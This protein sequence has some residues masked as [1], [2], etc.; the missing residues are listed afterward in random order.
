MILLQRIKTALESSAQLLTLLSARPADTKIYAFFA[1]EAYAAQANIGRLPFVL[2]RDISTAYLFESEPYHGSTRRCVL[3]IRICVPFSV[4]RQQTAMEQLQQI[5]L[6][7]LRALKHTP[8][9]DART[10]EIQ[11][12]QSVLSMV[13][14]VDF[15][16]TYDEDHA[17]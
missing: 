2:L 6:E 8:Y 4:N 3:E 12:S 9:T 17:E 1:G 5:K 10:R 14:E 11:Q 7:I 16:T 15:E 13:L